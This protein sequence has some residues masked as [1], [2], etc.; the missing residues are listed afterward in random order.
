MRPA[1]RYISSRQVQKLSSCWDLRSAS[2]AMARWKACE[3]IF[4]TPGRENMLMDEF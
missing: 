1:K 2:P 3:W 4:G